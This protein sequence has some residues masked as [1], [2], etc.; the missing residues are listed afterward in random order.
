MS[1]ML[2]VTDVSLYIQKKSI[3]HDI[4]FITAS[5]A[6]TGIIGPNGAGKSTLIRVLSRI[7]SHYNG[8]IMLKGKNIL[9]YSRRELAR[10]IGVLPAELHIPYDFSVDEIVCMGRIR[11]Y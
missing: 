10:I 9:D 1:N 5:G 2:T 6:F 7:Y 11:I 3:L 4:S 8:T